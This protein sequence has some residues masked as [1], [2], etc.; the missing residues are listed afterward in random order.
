[1]K[2]VEKQRREFV[3]YSALMASGA[4]LLPLYSC[5]TDSKQSTENKATETVKKEL[6]IQVY[7]VRNQL[8]KDFE[9]TMKSIAE[10]GYSYIEAYGM[11]KNGQ[12]LGK[13]PEEYKTAVE[14][15]G[16]EVISSHCSYFTDEEAEKML[17][18]AKEL[19]LKQLVIPSM[20]KEQRADYR[21]VAKNFNK[22]GEIFKGSGV[23][24]GYHNHAF[25]FE[26]QNGKAGLEILLENT[27][28]ELVQFQADLYWVVKGGA[29]PV[30]LI[31]RYPG[32]FCSFHVK[33]AAADLE[34][35]TV[36]EGI[37]D[38]KTVFSLKE[39]AGIDYFFVEDERTDSP[40]DNLTKAANYLNK[41]DFI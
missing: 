10:I 29:D 5:Q 11:G 32:R 9:G 1:M 34:Q 14:K 4:V 24:F 19:G 36:G 30:D 23:T 40:F 31:N 21:K 35:T 16:L 25:E 18:T 39:K 41:A 7:S 38:F 37:V 20:G 17:E 3:K 13:S 2:I 8:A 28:P 6:G 33:D 27:D 22:I 15:A 26:K 12:I